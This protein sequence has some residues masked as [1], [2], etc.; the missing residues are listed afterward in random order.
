MLRPGG[1][2]RDVGQVDLGLGA[3]GKLDLGLLGGFLQPL[4]RQLV[5][6][7]VHALLFLEL[8]GQIPDQEHVEI[9]AA[10]EGVAIGRLDLEQAVVDLQDRD[11]EGAAAEVVDRNRPGALLVEPVGQRRRGR[12]VDDAQHLEAGDLARVLGRL[13]LAVVEIGRHGDHRLGDRLAEV[14]LGGFLHLLQDIGRNLARRVLLAAGLDPG[15]AVLALDDVEGDHLLVLGH[16]RVGVTAPDQALD[17]EQGVFRVGDRLALGRLAHE[18]LAILGE[19]HHRGRGPR[20]FRVLDHLGL[21]P[22][23]DG[24]A[25]IGGS[26][27]DSDDFRHYACFP[28]LAIGAWVRK[29]PPGCHPVLTSVLRSGPGGYIGRAGRGCNTGRQERYTL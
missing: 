27:V 29:R 23:H 6:A 15:V 19:R 24:D 16:H 5:G 8:L 4:Q 12:L 10:E 2:R 21:G 3:G 26:E 9:L 7:Q 13:A 14:L 17:G 25:G 20:A 18:A 28:L 11:I 22:V 1:V